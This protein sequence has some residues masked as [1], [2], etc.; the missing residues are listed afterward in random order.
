MKSARIPA[1]RTSSGRFSSQWLNEGNGMEY[2]WFSGARR[3]TEA[4]HCEYERLSR[5]LQILP[6]STILRE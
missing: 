6:D 3:D 2:L 4:V 1:S 5:G